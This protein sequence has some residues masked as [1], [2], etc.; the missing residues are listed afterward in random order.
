[1]MFTSSFL[2]IIKLVHSKLSNFVPPYTL[3]SVNTIDDS[4]HSPSE[5]YLVDFYDSKIYLKHLTRRQLHDKRVLYCHNRHRHHI[6]WDNGMNYHYRKWKFNTESKY[7][8]QKVKS[9][10]QAV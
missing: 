2:I 10:L 5:E 9:E 4:T 8:K 1:M 7:K 3:E 6:N